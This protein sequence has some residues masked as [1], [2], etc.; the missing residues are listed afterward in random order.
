MRLLTLFFLFSFTLLNAQ[1]EPSWRIHYQGYNLVFPGLEVAWEYPLLTKSF[2]DNGRKLQA[3]VAPTTE[4]YYHAGNHTGFSLNGDLSLKYTTS[5]G[6]EYLLFGSVGALEAVL[7]G[8]VYE[9]GDNGEFTSSKL[10]G[11][12]Y[13][14]WK[15]GF[16]IGKS[17]PNKPF[18]VNL[19]AGVRQARFPAP[20]LTP[21]VSLGVN[22][23]I[24]Q[25]NN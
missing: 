16:G 10:K 23:L 22:W 3:V 14:Q 7:A 2:G 25:K 17:I 13:S 8:E 5:K 18:V 24:N 20:E 15:A 9:L 11:N 19:R 1:N 12:L 4:F 6:F 21:N